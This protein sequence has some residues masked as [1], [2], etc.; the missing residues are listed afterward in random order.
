MRRTM[1]KERGSRWCS[2]VAPPLKCQ[3]VLRRASPASLSRPGTCA[4]RV[5]WAHDAGGAGLPPRSCLPRFV[6]PRPVPAPLCRSENRA[7]GLLT[8]SDRRG[9]SLRCFWE[10]HGSTRSMRSPGL[11]PC[12]CPAPKL[13]ALVERP[14]LCT[15][16]LRPLPLLRSS[17]FYRKGR[18]RSL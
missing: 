9:L 1:E 15:S 18:P 17:S 7:E 8:G 4:L 6:H 5:S 16:S 14:T 2:S 13:S 10:P 11:P 3:V 12:Y